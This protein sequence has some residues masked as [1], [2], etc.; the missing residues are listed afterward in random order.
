MSPL[1]N[2]IYAVLRRRLHAPSKSI[3]YKELAAAVSS[4]PR[5]SKLHAALTE[6]TEACLSAKLPALP[7]I[8][9]SATKS[10]PSSGYYEAAHPRARTDEGKLAAWEAEHERVLRFVAK[11][12]ARL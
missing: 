2:S 10:R 1:A 5:S 3:T 4:H 12:P 11:F 9:W 6:V 8:V 7:A